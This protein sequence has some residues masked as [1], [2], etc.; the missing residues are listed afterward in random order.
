[1]PVA[2]GA[3]QEG[4]RVDG[5][6]REHDDVAGVPLCRAIGTLDD[7]AGHRATGRVRLE[8]DHFRVPLESHVAVPE[9]RPD[10][11]DVR[12]RL[13]VD[14]AREAVEARAA[15]ADALVRVVLVQVHADGQVEGPSARADEIVVELLDPGLV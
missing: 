14:E 7:Y 15:N 11:E 3:E 10:T 4:G 5:T 9:R 8:P 1:M 13:A 12:V 2:R 6:G